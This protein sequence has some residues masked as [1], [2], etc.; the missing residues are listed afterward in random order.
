MKRKLNGGNLLQNK[1]FPKILL[2]FKNGYKIEIWYIKYYIFITLKILV[3]LYMKIK[4]LENFETKVK[5]I[6]ENG[7]IKTPIHLSGNNERQLIRIFK[8]INKNDWIF[9]SWRNHYHALLHGINE[10]WLLKQIVSGKSMGI[11]SKKRKY[12]HHGT[13]S[14]ILF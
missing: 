2:K 14:W 7:K 5:K 4:D 9:S 12:P 8:K 1:K 13:G 10:K 11:I 3:K 6:Y